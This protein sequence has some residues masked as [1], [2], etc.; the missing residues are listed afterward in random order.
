MAEQSHPYG[1][2]E[3]WQKRAETRQQIIDRQRRKIAHL[4]RR[5]AR[6]EKQE[7]RQ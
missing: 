2:T 1:T 6:A 3:Y 7:V 4:E 5:L